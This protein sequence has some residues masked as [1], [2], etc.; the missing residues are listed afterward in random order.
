MN[1]LSTKT[2]K[3]MTTREVAEALGCAVN[4][5]RETAKD[6]LPNKVFENG[7]TTYWTESEVTVVLEAMKNHNSN[8]NNLSRSLTG[9]STSLT[10]ALKI[11]KALELMRE[12]YE[13][14]LARIE[15]E[16]K[17]LALEKE[18]AEA[19]TERIY[20]VNKN[21]HNN[22]YTA[23]DLAKMLGTSS[24]KIGKIANEHNLKQDPIYGKLGKVQL[25]NGRWVEI[26]YYND[27][28]K[29]IIENNL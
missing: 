17:R 16:N 7:K 6:V 8:Q 23:T 14:E 3:T 11:Q 19:E 4:T 27:D 28:A 1:E 5:L 10:P 25:N 15:A 24:N 26:F 20:Q 12:G 18:A 21:F 22:L 9:V 2:E 13:E 29:F